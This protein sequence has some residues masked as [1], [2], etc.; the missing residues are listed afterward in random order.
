FQALPLSAPPSFLPD[1]PSF[2][3]VSL[4]PCFAFFHSFLAHSHPFGFPSFLSLNEGSRTPKTLKFPCSVCGKRFRF[5]SILALHM[6][7][8]TGEKPYQCPYCDHRAA[9]KGNLKIHLKTHKESTTIAAVCR[10]GL[11]TTEARH[12]MASDAQGTWH[13][14][15]GQGSISL[16]NAR[17]IMEEN[18]N[19]VGFS[20]KC[21]FCKG[22]FRTRDEL[23]RHQ[24]ILH[25]PYRCGHCQYAAASEADL[26][27]HTEVR[28]RSESG[29]VELRGKAGRKEGGNGE[30]SC[31]TICGQSFAQA[32]FLKSHMRK[33][34][35]SFEHPC[36]ICGRRFKEPWFLKN[37]MRVHSSGRRPISRS[38]VPLP[39]PSQDS[40][41][42]VVIGR[43]P[44]KAINMFIP[45]EACPACGLLFTDKTSLAAHAEVHIRDTKGEEG[46]AG[47]EKENCSRRVTQ[48]HSHI[49]SVENMMT[50]GPRGR[51]RGAQPKVCS[52]CNKTFRTSNHLKVHLRVHTGEK[53]YKCTYCDYAGTQSSSL[54]YHLERHHPV[55]WHAGKPLIT[56]R[57]EHN[58]QRVIAPADQDDPVKG[59]C[60]VDE[61]VAKENSQP[62]LSSITMKRCNKAEPNLLSKCYNVTYCC[63]SGVAGFLPGPRGHPHHHHLR[64]AERFLPVCNHFWFYMPIERIVPRR[65]T[66]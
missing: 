38:A 25:R 1:P 34:K 35:V 19:V 20:F 31:C 17:L 30:S 22:K 5:N 56:C 24:I 13:C 63:G 45:I 6:R 39:S 61:N 15:G 7:T 4:S 3:L 14:E 9:Q 23:E 58:S 51:A 18:S 42:Q 62:E 47:I 60:N 48:V 49:V 33:H 8:H 55:A 43:N 36:T 27:S 40:D 53:P 12:L 10:A 64:D 54:K 44:H 50:T 65:D 41:P 21:S 32:W 46:T 37:H 28:H 29:S 66:N 11:S 59:P 52:Y 16:A 2:V 57:E 26:L